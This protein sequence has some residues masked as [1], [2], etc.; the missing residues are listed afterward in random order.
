MNVPALHTQLI[1]CLGEMPS[2]LELLRA[3]TVDSPMLEFV[4]F[5]RYLHFR[6]IDPFQHGF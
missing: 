4:M 5:V 3:M 1:L 2:D 6:E